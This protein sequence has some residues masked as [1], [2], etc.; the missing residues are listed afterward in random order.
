MATTAP[1]S[2]TVGTWA[3]DPAHSNVEFSVRHMMVSTVKGNFGKVEGTMQVDA[4]DHAASIVEAKVDVASITTRD[5]NR[6]GHLKSAD[7]FN[8]EQY[9]TMTFKGTKNER[10]DTTHYRVTGDLTIRDVTKPVTFVTEV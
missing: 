5:E 9:P 3:I 6:D 1:I 4:N 7:F 2:Q 8:A 10:I